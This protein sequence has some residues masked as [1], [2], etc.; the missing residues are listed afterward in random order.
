MKLINK[1]KYLTKD[2]KKLFEKIIKENGIKSSDI[3]VKVTTSK[4]K[5]SFR[6]RSFEDTVHGTAYRWNNFIHMRIPEKLQIITYNKNGRRTIFRELEKLDMEQTKMVARVFEHELDHIRGID[7]HIDMVNWWEKDV[8]Y[9]GDV[10]I[11]K[12]EDIK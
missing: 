1:T 5:R 8:E 10:E 2:L 12:R 7:K 11:Q 6:R 3:E 9:I 4:I